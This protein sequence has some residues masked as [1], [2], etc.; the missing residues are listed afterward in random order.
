MKQDLSSLDGDTIAAIATP[1]GRGGIGIVRISGPAATAIGRSLCR[2]E[3]RP[4]YAHYCDFYPPQE[5]EALDSGIALSFPGPHSFT[6]E[7]VVELQ[8][9]GGPVILDLLLQACCQAGA[10]TAR[11]GEFSERAF[12]NGKLDLAQAE[13]IS[14]LINST[15]SAAGTSACHLDQVRP[16]VASPWVR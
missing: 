7:D 1:P 4:R 15:T 6:G 14:D 5:A 11:A 8:A 16:T 2:Q 13:A 10:R 9:H 3:L 12:L